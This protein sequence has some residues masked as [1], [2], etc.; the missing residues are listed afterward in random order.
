VERLLRAVRDA[1]TRVLLLDFDGTLAPF[2][3]DRESVRLYDG[4]RPVLEEIAALP[5]HRLVFVTGRPAGQLQRL[6]DF[7][8]I[9][10]IWGSHGME[11]LAPDGRVM[12]SPLPVGAR[13]VLDREAEHV[14]ASFGAEHLERK[15]FG[16]ALHVRGLEPGRAEGA[17]ATMK[18]RWRRLSGMNGLRV[19][20]FDG[21][22]ELGAGTR[23]KG[24]AVASALRG[25]DGPVAAA[26]LG[27]DLTD[28]DAFRAMRG[29]GTAILVR[30]E[31]RPTAAD[32]WLRPPGELIEFLTEWR[33]AATGARA[34]A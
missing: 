29:R 28:E 23:H 26:F 6:L 27:D 19:K 1:R 15:P 16:I 30:D 22:I 12:A 20:I 13:D 17:V 3:V 25:L 4:V 2:S 14:R 31:L 8:W 34:W 18:E 10:S 11:Q 5:R 33:D 21:G 9:P 24:D 32:A 7:E